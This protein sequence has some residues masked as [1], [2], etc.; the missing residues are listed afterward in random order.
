MNI[1]L[2]AHAPLAI[3][4]HLAT[5]IP[6]FFLGSWLI[7]LSPKGSRYHRLLGSIYLALMTT[8]AIAAMFIHSLNPGRMSWLHIFVPLTLFGVF[9]AIWRIRRK[10]VAGHRAAMVGLYFGGLII[11][12]AL[13]FVPGRLMYRLFFE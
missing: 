4:I 11:A 3:Q 7:F 12:G 13:T 10:D 5:V 2:A 1:E 9:S 6:A 8:T